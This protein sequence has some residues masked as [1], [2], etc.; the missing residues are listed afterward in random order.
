MF[1]LF[2]YF[3]VVYF[4]ATFPYLVLVILLFRGLLLD[5]HAEGIH[6]YITPDWTKLADAAVKFI[7][8][9]SA[10]RAY[11]NGDAPDRIWSKSPLFILYLL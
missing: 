5:G 10:F 8:N 4:T 2:I 3:Q 6:F 11:T 1:Y 7:Y 9:I